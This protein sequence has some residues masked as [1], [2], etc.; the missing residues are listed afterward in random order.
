M[1]EQGD[2]CIVC[3]IPAFAR[4]LSTPTQDKARSYVDINLYSRELYEFTSIRQLTITHDLSTSTVH[5]ATDDFIS[6]R[7]F[8]VT[9][10]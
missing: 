9:P 5:F 2:D 8:R 7:L 6:S 3:F 10:V 1:Q 4:Y